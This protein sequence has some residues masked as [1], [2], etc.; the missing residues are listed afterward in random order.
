M[1]FERSLAT[2]LERRLSR[3][4]LNTLWPTSPVNSGLGTGRANKLNL[5]LKVCFFDRFEQIKDDSTVSD[6]KHYGA[7]FYTPEVFQIN[8]VCI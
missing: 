4:P 3:R 8:H 1:L 2:V 5:K 6:A 7:V